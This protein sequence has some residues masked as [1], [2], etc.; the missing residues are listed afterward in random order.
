MSGITMGIQALGFFIIEFIYS[1]VQSLTFGG[2]GRIRTSG[3]LAGTAV[4]ETAPFGHSGTPPYLKFHAKL[5]LIF[6][7]KKSFLSC[8]YS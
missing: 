7:S 5:N 2:G 4:F 1:L 8:V 6:Y 3:T